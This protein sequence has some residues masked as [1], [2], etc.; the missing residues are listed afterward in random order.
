MAT[1][2]TDHLA[3]VPRLAIDIPL[4]LSGRGYWRMNVSFLNE[5]TFR[6]VLQKQWSRWQQHKKFYPNRVVCVCVGGGVTLRKEDGASII[7]Q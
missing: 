2:F 7:H 6:G 1:A 3:V 5:K 4:P